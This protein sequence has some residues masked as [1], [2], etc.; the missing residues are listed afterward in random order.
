MNACIAIKTIKLFA[1]PVIQIIIQIK[2]NYA[3]FVI[4]RSIYY[5][6]LFLSLYL[7]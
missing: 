3:S 5:L 7:L 6:K 2:V 4:L 1:T